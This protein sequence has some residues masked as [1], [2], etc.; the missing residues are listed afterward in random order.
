M[1]V[2]TYW[3]TYIHTYT[4]IHERQYGTEQQWESNQIA[5][6]IPAPPANP[7]P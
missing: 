6:P 1:T 2:V 7:Q 4:P 5:H 3:N